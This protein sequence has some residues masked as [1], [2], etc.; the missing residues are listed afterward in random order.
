[1]NARLTA[2]LAMLLLAAPVLAAC[3][4]GGEDG[5][6]EATATASSPPTAASTAT[7]N[8]D[9]TSG[10]NPDSGSVPDPDRDRNPDPD[11]DRPHVRPQSGF[12]LSP[13][14]GP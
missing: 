7:P 8:R 12:G 4:D 11:R 10:P 1:M 5:A 2:L 3:T 13:R 14:P 9:P 6:G